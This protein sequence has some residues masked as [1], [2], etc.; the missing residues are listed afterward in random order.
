MNSL[1]PGLV[2]TEGLH[3][4][5]FAESEW[6]NQIEKS[7]RLERIGQPNDIAT[8]VVFFASD[9]AGWVIGQPLVLSSEARQ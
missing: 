5:G 2:E 7:T 8:A 3:T 4:A 1:N 9:D 6:R